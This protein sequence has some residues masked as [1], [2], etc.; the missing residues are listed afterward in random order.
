MGDHGL[1]GPIRITRGEHL[2]EP[3]MF[4]NHDL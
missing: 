2:A 1:L 4:V 3:Q